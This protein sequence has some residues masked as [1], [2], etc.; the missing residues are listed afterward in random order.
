MTLSPRPGSLTSRA[1]SLAAWGY[2]AD[3][4]L[5]SLKDVDRFIDEE[6][7]GG[8]PKPGSHMAQ[9]F[10]VSFLGNIELDPEVRK[11]GDSGKPVVLA[12]EDSAHAKSLYAFA[13][14]VEARVEEIKATAPASVIQIQ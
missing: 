8:K 1:K 12:G 2:K 5:E 7:P 13:R 10:G 14:K 3:F 9:Q 11:Y 6:A 4:S